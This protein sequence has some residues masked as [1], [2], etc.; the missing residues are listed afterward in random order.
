MEDNLKFVY[1]MRYK[2]YYLCKKADTL[3]EIVC[4]LYYNRKILIKSIRNW[5]GFISNVHEIQR[6]CY[7]IKAQ[8]KLKDLADVTIKKNLN[9][10]SQYSKEIQSKKSFHTK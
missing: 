4:D 9:I 8:L 1:F 6:I 7:Q 10:F 5:R 3:K 2:K